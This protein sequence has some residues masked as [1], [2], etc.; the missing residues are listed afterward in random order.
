MCSES[1]M[2]VLM[3]DQHTSSLSA[4]AKEHVLSLA[5]ALRVAGPVA[6]VTAVAV[7]GTLG[8]SESSRAAVPLQQ[9]NRLEIPS[10]SETIRTAALASPEL[11]RPSAASIP[12]SAP[13]EPWVRSDAASRA[14]DMTPL[15]TPKQ[16][17][18]EQANIARFIAARYRLTVEATT[19]FVHHAYLA[20]RDMRIDPM[21]V[22]AV[23]S[24]ESSFNPNAQSS[25]GAQGLMQV[26]TR[27]HM[28]KFLPFGGIRAAFD[29]VASIRVGSAIL[30]DYISREGSVE[31]GLKSYVG[32]ALMD[33]D[34]GYGAKVLNARDRIAAA[35]AGT[36]PPPEYAP[37]PAPKVERVALVRRAAETSE[38]ANTLTEASGAV[39]ASVEP[40][41]E[42]MPAVLSA[43]GAAAPGNGDL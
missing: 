17:S 11:P 30:R 24:V 5:R 12:E 1:C 42:P 16:L 21:L 13:I 2:G 26:L 25:A 23:M 28:E 15:K 35:A 37:A 34:G 22:L 19:E 8:G 3:S 41:A 27:V 40:P 43:P 18:R 4:V 39:P 7:H 6:L 29:P 20:A 9:A 33:N 36:L 14:A 31:G 10:A 38:T 32:A